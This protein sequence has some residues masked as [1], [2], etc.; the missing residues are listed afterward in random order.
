MLT[1]H[2]TL[3]RA[4]SD[5]PAGPS[6]GAAGSDAPVDD[7]VEAATPPIV[8]SSAFSM[9]DLV[10]ALQSARPPPAMPR[11][12][13]SAPDAFSGKGHL[14]AVYRPACEAWLRLS[15]VPEQDAVQALGL[16]TLQGEAQRWFYITQQLQ[17]FASL[18]DY[19]NRLHEQYGYRD[20][21]EYVNQQWHNLRQGNR[22]VQQFTRDFEALALRVPGLTE[23]ERLRKYRYSLNDAI[24]AKL[25]EDSATKGLALRQLQS[26]AV[27][28]E[29][30]LKLS[31]AA[32]STFSAAAKRSTPTWKGRGSGNTGGGGS[33]APRQQQS[34]GP[35]F[36]QRNQPIVSVNAVQ[37]TGPNKAP[38]TPRTKTFLRENDG[39]F[40]CRTPNAGHIAKDCPHRP[41]ASGGA[42]NA[43][44]R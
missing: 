31:A 3:P 26:T 16:R 39:C 11:L 13:L 19:F 14:S 7:S 28:K 35:S 9:A 41:Q 42:G 38:I 44:S 23:A 29:A 8:D 27:D 43:R 2:T 1:A 25:Q 12:S 24:Q 37:S 5:A 33:N 21:H 34:S 36:L 17:E 40:Y 4:A 15:R 10:A 22:T 20:E 18:D 6:A 32:S 30:A